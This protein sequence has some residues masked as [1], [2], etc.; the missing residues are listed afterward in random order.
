MMDKDYKV[1]QAIE[2]KPTETPRFGGISPSKAWVF[3]WIIVEGKWRPRPFIDAPTPDTEWIVLEW[4]QKSERTVD[5][6]DVLW[7]IQS[8]RDLK[9]EYCHSYYLLFARYEL[10]DFAKALYSVL[11]S[12]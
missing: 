9:H 1:A 12:E 10:G 6:I 3:K 4:V 7:D 5:F 11:E 2:P 8:G